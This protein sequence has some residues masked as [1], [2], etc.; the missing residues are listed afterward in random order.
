MKALILLAL[1][2][3]ATGSAA[4]FPCHMLLDDV[5]VCRNKCQE[6]HQ[7]DTKICLG[8]IKEHDSHQ[9]QCIEQTGHEFDA[10][11]CACKHSNPPADLKAPS[12]QG[13]ANAD[14][15]P[16]QGSKSDSG[17]AIAH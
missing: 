2:Y 15:K 3:A 9:S 11:V 10:C 4:L 1:L 17:E 14:S 5:S 13:S 12:N 8:G 6:K 16:A 7:Q